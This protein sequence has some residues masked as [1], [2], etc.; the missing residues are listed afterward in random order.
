MRAV[1]IVDGAL[2]WREHPDPEPGKGEVLVAIEA[3]GGLEAGDALGDRA[4]GGEIQLAG[5]RAA[6]RFLPHAARDSRG[7]EDHPGGAHELAEAATDKV[8]GQGWVAADGEENGD[9]EAWVL[10]GWGPP[11]DPKRYTVQGYY[12]NERGN[13]VGLW[14]N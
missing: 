12:T 8:P 1:T 11:A 6:A 13:T 2:E 10:F 3:A 5:R 9:L 7:A 4:F 14:H